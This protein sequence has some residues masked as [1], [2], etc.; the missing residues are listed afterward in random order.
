MKYGLIVE[1]VIITKMRVLSL[2]L[3][4]FGP[5]VFGSF[6]PSKPTPKPEIEEAKQHLARCLGAED[7][8]KEQKRVS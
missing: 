7:S 2:F 1:S 4:G 6:W 8:V 5:F 3:Q